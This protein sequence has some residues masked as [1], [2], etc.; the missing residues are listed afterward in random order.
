MPTFLS[1]TATSMS[2]SRV[3]FVLSLTALRWLFVPRGCCVFHVPKRNQHLIRS[4]L[5]TSHGWEAR[6]CPDGSKKDIN[7]PLPPSKKSVF[8]TQFEFVGTIDNAPYLCVPEAIRWRQDA[9]GGEAAIRQYCFRLAREGGA[10]A[11]R[12]LDTDVLENSDGTFGDC[13]FSNVRLPLVVSAPSRPSPAA[14][15]IPAEH[16]SDALNWILRQLVDIHDTF[17]ALIF[18]GGTLYA[19][20]S[21]QV[22]LEPADFE[23][24]ATLL[25]DLCARVRQGEYLHAT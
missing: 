1:A 8:V 15:E 2:T 17:I 24:G 5:P 13:C 7:N 22:Y 11:A 19:R 12:I 14:G 9:C 18:F 20:L 3:R 23:M 4:S 6:P 10:A 16:V 25:R 21:A